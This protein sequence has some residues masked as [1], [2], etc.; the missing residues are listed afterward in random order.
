MFHLYLE[1]DITYHVQNK[2]EEGNLPV[3]NGEN[4][5]KHLELAK[6]H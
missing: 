5:T 6:F 1:D 4:K 3:R 2:L